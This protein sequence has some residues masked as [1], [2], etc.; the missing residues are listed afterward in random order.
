[1]TFLTTFS[2]LPLHF[3]MEK[4][5]SQALKSQLE[6]RNQ[7]SRFKEFF[8]VLSNAS[9][10]SFFEEYSQ[11]LQKIKLLA[12]KSKK[13][14]DNL[15]DSKKLKSEIQSDSKIQSALKQL[16]KRF[17]WISNSYSQTKVLPLKHFEQELINLL[18]AQE[19]KA[20]QDLTKQKKQALKEMKPNKRLR[21]ILK[22]MDFM[23]QFQDDRKKNNL[24]ANHYLDL[25]LKE[26]S[27]R[28][29]YSREELNFLMPN[30]I[31]TII[32]GRQIAK[33]AISERMQNMWVYFSPENTTILT[34]EKARKENESIRGKLDLGKVMEL[35]GTTASKGVARGICRIILS[36]TELEKLQPGEILV[37]S[38]TRPEFVPAMKRAAAIV[39]DEGG[40]TCH[41]AI[42]SRELG[43]PC[44]VGT[45]I[46]TKVLRNGETVEV[47]GGHGIVRKINH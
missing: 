12:L 20:I 30:E 9:F 43:L 14:H 24:M 13:I 35:R 27:K 38:M 28:T 26:I 10:R 46:A 42:V 37:T 44:V 47:N 22:L 4:E 6:S 32:N 19:E 18:S 1:M 17:F 5:F 39:T 23:G 40:L 21:F 8:Q 29:G 2:A 45:R 31:E 7:I 25:I 3:G 16:Q 36:A 33:N 41:A 15:R 11:V 34:G